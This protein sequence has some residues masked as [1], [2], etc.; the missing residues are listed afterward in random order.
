LKQDMITPASHSVR[1]C[2]LEEVRRHLAGI[3]QKT[4]DSA[5]TSRQCRGW[6]KEKQ[7]ISYALE[8]EEVSECYT[9]GEKYVR[10]VVQGADGNSASTF[11][12]PDLV[13][14]KQEKRFLKKFLRKRSKCRTS[15]W[16][17]APARTPRSSSLTPTPTADK[18]DG[19]PTSFS[20]MLK[21]V[22]RDLICENLGCALALDG[23]KGQR[24]L[25]QAVGSR[26]KARIWVLD[27]SRNNSDNFDE[28]RADVCPRQVTG[29]EDGSF[30]TVAAAE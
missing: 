15:K 28:N 17:P 19:K 12:N 30:T 6:N 1:V 10:V 23:R 22:E 7:R 21:G 2:T 11:V 5:G 14:I 13:D 25:L 3:E 27:E 18:W 16:T 24:V 29:H 20:I 9:K 8:G 26:E 4:R